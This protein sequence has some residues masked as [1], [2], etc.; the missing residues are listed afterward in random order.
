MNIKKTAKTAGIVVLALLGFLLV[1]SLFGTAVHAAGLVD[2]TVDAAN[3]YS[4]YAL[5][6]YQLDFYVDSSWDW[7]PWNWTDGIGKGI[8]YALY[9]I[10][11]FIWT[12]SLYISNATGYVVQEAYQLNFISDTADEIGRN[13]QT[14]AGVTQSGFSSEGF[15]VGFLLILVLILGIYVAYTGLFKRETTKAVRAAINFVVIFI[16]SASFIA[17][18]PNYI[19]KINGFSSD[20]STAALSL[21]TKI[22]LPE[23]ESKGKDSVD[24]IRDSLFAIQVKQPWLLLQYG[25]SDTEAIGT[26]RIDSLLAAEPDTDDREDIV[27]GEIED[28]ENDYLSVKKTMSRMGTVF[29]LF[30]FN[31]GISIFVF[32]LTGMMIFSQVLF[33]IFAMFLPVS[34]LLSMIPTFESKS[35]EALTKLF[36]TIMMRAGIT[37]VITAAFSISTMFYK[38]STGYPFFM[39]AFLQIVTFAGIYFKMGDLMSMFSLHS[40][41]SQQMGRKIFRRPVMLLGH[42]ARRMERRIGRSIK[43]GAATVTTGAA[44]GAVAGSLYSSR[45]TNKQ[46][47]TSRPVTAADSNAGK[48]TGAKVG[49]VLDSKNRVKDKAQEVGESIKDMPTQARYAVHSGVSQ[50]KENASSFKR[51]IV[52][53]K[54]NR[55]QVRSERMNNR[56]QSIAQKRLELEQ[57]KWDAGSV[58]HDVPSKGTAPAN[59]DRPAVKPVSRAETPAV[60]TSNFEQVKRER[61]VISGN[62][63]NNQYS[64]NESAKSNTPVRAESAKVQAVRE[65]TTRVQGS[66][67]KSHVTTN[68]KKSVNKQN[69]RTAQRT[70][71]DS[72][73]GRRK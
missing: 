3:E 4:K 26:D 72:K 56:R 18:A 49:A 55:Q 48:R 14:L 15:Y 46:P 69:Q 11:N 10:T 28:E 58:T 24:L 21:G 34:F 43:A 44:A 16:L 25:T 36:N 22:V 70:T 13:I 65:T 51:G 37:L 63:N 27:K 9:A 8:Q 32:L 30:F 66:N 59:H 5:G 7:L 68:T 38:I 54:E 23:S 61:P 73:K 60:N 67:Q 2:D 50:I 6:N 1:L 29:F 17:Y 52:E 47:D 41:D 57:K 42:R 71:K 20:V 40:A 35:K 19:E 12:V 39:V 62:G 33:I 64:T 31:I 53:E 45:N